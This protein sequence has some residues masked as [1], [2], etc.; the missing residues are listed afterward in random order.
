MSSQNYLLGYK[1]VAL[2]APRVGARA[3]VEDHNSSLQMPVHI[4]QMEVGV[5]G[6]PPW[7]SLNHTVD[8]RGHL[9]EGHPLSTLRK[10]R[11]WMW[12]RIHFT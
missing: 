2:I 7:T 5:A 12:W 3:F 10:D 1:N 9:W 11:Q 4:I 8:G 6:L